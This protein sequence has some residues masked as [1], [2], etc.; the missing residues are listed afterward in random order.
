MNEQSQSA[1]DQFP[2]SNFR[3]TRSADIWRGMSLGTGFG[4]H[5]IDKSSSKWWWITHHSHSRCHSG[6]YGHHKDESLSWRRRKNNRN[7]FPRRIRELG[8]VARCV[9]EGIG[10]FAGTPSQKKGEW[11]FENLER[12]T[13]ES[14]YVHA[15]ITPTCRS[16]LFCHPTSAPT[17]VQRRDC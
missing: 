6:P 9:W 11:F 8:A 15:K 16:K 3:D 4:S 10:W 1:P 2:A 12:G 14:F 7:I 17:R 13:D 5:L